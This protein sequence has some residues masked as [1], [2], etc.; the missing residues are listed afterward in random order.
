M[1]LYF[2]CDIEQVASARSDLGII[3]D[4]IDDKEAGQDSFDNSGH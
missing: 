2:Q 4:N 3:A 1:L